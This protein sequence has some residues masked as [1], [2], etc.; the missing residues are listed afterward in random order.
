MV[1]LYIYKNFYYFATVWEKY[2]NFPTYIIRQGNSYSFIK[3]RKDGIL[4]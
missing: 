2:V 3:L 4:L 1:A